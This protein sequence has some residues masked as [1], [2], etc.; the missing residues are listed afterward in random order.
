MQLAAGARG[1]IPLAAQTAI[2]VGGS[3]SSGSFAGIDAGA[4][5]MPE[6]SRK[7]PPIW[8]WD[9]A[10]FA[11]LEVS[12]EQDLGRFVMRPFVG[13]GYLLNGGDGTATKFCAQTPCEPGLR[14]RVVPFFGL[15]LAFGLL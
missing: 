5:V 4:I 7:S 10:H 3:W 2:G 11:N 8:Y 12:L 6:M 13:A 1:R 9:R 15:A 14:A